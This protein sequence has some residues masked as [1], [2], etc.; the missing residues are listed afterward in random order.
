MFTCDFEPCFLIL[1]FIT[2]IQKILID[3]YFKISLYNGSTNKE[4]Y[5]LYDVVKH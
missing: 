5:M 1:Y 2:C 4:N 3:Q